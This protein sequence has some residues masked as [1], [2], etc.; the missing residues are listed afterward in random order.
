MDK[1]VGPNDRIGYQ[2]VANSKRHPLS[3]AEQAGLAKRAWQN[4]PGKTG[5]AVGRLLLWGTP[6]LFDALTG[7]IKIGRW[8]VWGWSRRSKR[9]CAI[10][11]S[12]NSCCRVCQ[13][14][15]DVMHCGFLGGRYFYL[16]GDVWPDTRFSRKS[17]PGDVHRPGWSFGQPGWFWHRFRWE[18]ALRQPACWDWFGW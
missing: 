10:F 2:A 1:S 7:L 12:T 9:S 4:G 11:T 17:C 18:F 16:P 5:L 3:V 14:G 13:A 15:V 6:R 8:L